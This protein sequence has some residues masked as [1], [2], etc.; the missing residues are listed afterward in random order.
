MRELRNQGGQVLELVERGQC[1]TVTRDGKPVAELRP[2][3]RRSLPTAELVMR[4]KKLPRVDPDGLR[5]DIDTW[6]DQS[7]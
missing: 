4:A 6:I 2:I 3:N 7:L 5:N 1:F